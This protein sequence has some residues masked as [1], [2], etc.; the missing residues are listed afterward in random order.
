MEQNKLFKPCIRIKKK[1][2]SLHS[3]TITGVIEPK[4]TQFPYDL[5]YNTY[6]FSTVLNAYG[7]KSSDKSNVTVGIIELGG[8]YLSSD[9]E[10]CMTANGFP[11]W[12]AID[13]VFPVF[14]DNYNDGNTNVVENFYADIDS[15]LEVALD[16]EFVANCIPNGKINVYFAPNT[17]SGDSFIN[18]VNRA[19]D[20][21]CTT[22]SISWGA[23]EFNSSNN[24]IYSFEK[25]FKKAS[26]KGIS[27]F[28]ANGDFGDVTDYT[29]SIQ[30]N[31][32][33]Y[34]VGYPS[35]SPNVVCCGGTIL[36]LELQNG[37]YSKYSK[38]TTWVE[39]VGIIV[40]GNG[41]VSTLFDKPHYQ[42][43]LNFKSNFNSNPN[44]RGTPDVSGNASV[45][46]GYTVYFNGETTGVGGVSAVSPMWAGFTA[47]LGCNV[48]INPY[49]YKL[50]KKCFND[51]KHGINYPYESKEG[52]DLC[53][54]LGTPNG[55]VLT[56]VLKKIFIK[57]SC[58]KCKKK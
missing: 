42:K 38:E 12:K 46:N 52:Y 32:L 29:S 35:S 51:I 22:I 4:I 24:Y 30:N 14:I 49:L 19:I 2:N 18:A 36:S 54:G 6:A 28:V 45:Y 25:V 5:D 31:T 11:L 21:N 9:L 39:D 16:V 57:K 1:D 13:H 43:D 48:F 23:Y 26:S 33:G 27:I 3:S 53:T 20:D 55:K 40:A 34:Q 10:A 37:T 17:F 58:K 50:P 8:G 41:G 15:S 47:G 56:K 7:I 44:R